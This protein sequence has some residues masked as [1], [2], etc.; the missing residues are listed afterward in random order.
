[1]SQ[2]IMSQLSQGNKS[3][4]PAP[5]WSTIPAAVLAAFPPPTPQNSWLGY[6]CGT[7]I[8]TDSGVVVGVTLPS[9]PLTPAPPVGGHWDVMGS[10]PT[11]VQSLGPFPPVANVLAVAQQQQ[12]SG[13]G[14][15]VFAQQRTSPIIYIFL[16]G[17]AVRC[18]FEI[19]CPE[20]ISVNGQT[21]ILCN[22]TDMGEG[23]T[24]RVI[25]ESIRPIFAAKWKL[26]YVLTGTIP[27]TAIPTVR[28]HG[29]A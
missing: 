23:F 4:Q 28:A 15:E 7:Y 2:L 27:L 1:M 11:G 22:R 29:L 19:P 10:L 12:Q 21:P 3:L 25:G 6:R 18:G 26:R 24:R 20:I 9:E 16:E 5:N 17:E 8:E 14:S 13:A